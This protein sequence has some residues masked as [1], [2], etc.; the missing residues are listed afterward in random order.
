MGL[1]ND[2]LGDDAFGLEVARRLRETSAAG[3]ADIV[4]CSASGF[5][6]LDYLDGYDHA[7]LI[8]SYLSPERRFG[9][10]IEL[11]ITDHEGPLP[12]SGSHFYSFSQALAA[13]RK[14]GMRLPV[15]IKAYCAVIHDYTFSDKGIS[16][17]LETAAGVIIGSITGRLQADWITSL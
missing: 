11:D 12:S 9:E 2:I 17:E 16:P 8:D 14:M 1:G 3:S 5:R 10:V 6:I 13:G 7:V 4:E 15:K